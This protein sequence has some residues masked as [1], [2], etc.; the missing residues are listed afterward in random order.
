[1]TVRIGEQEVSAI[2]AGDLSVLKIFKGETEVYAA[3]GGGIGPP[4]DEYHRYWRVLFLRANG[5]PWTNITKL[6]LYEQDG[7]VDYA[8][9]ATVTTNVTPQDGNLDNLKDSDANT[10]CQW[11]TE[12]FEVKYDMGAG[13]IRGISRWI[14]GGAVAGVVNRSAGVFVVQFS[15]DDSTWMTHMVGLPAGTWTSDSQIKTFD[16]PVWDGPVDYWGITVNHT[17]R[18]YAV[19]AELTMHATPGGPNL[20]ASVTEVRARDYYSSDVPEN[21]FDGD[22]NTFWGSATEYPPHFLVC[23]LPS[24]AI[25]EQIG[26][27]SRNDS[28]GAEDAPQAGMVIFGPDGI[29]YRVYFTYAFSGWSDFSDYKTF[30]NPSIGQLT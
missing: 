28:L 3:G 1:M 8:Q 9:T 4:A 6:S 5:G 19:F 26:I 20:A 15:D 14:I 7:L 22:V 30:T 29:N 12:T 21:A 13:N 24:A 23:K 17:D 18:G 2:Y 11:S 10:Y 25:I 16:L 27:R